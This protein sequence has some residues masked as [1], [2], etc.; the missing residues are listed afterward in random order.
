MEIKM[1]KVYPYKDNDDY[2][3]YKIL[4]P[5]CDMSLMEIH[6]WQGYDV[7]S[8]C[9]SLRADLINQRNI[10][11]P[12]DSL[13]KEKI[14][15]SIFSCYSCRA[16]NLTNDEQFTLKN[17]IYAINNLYILG[18]IPAVIKYLERSI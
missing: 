11:L 16:T 6:K 1:F 10:K 5:F 14:E 4:C 18:G 15:N 17:D 7:L 13:L 12:F 9:I 8:L 3:T 2:C